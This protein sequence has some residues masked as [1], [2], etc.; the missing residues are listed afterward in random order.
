VTAAHAVNKLEKAKRAVLSRLAPR[1]VQRASKLVAMIAGDDAARR[2]ELA[3][4][5][6]TVMATVGNFV[7]GRR[8]RRILEEMD[9]DPRLSFQAVLARLEQFEGPQRELAEAE[10][11]RMVTHLGDAIAPEA[12]RPML[13]AVA[14]WCEDS[15]Q[16]ED[17]VNACRAL[18]DLD[19]SELDQLA[20]LVAQSLARGDSELRLTQTGR[21]ERLLRRLEDCD[22]AR[23]EGAEIVLKRRR[24]ELLRDILLGSG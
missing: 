13:R 18:R 1:A 9:R 3:G 20:E 19:G 14:V 8:A 4:A 17:C 15:L 24:A 12:V 23:L 21:A 16:R 6:T 2:A 22:L 10:V 7:S 5:F 11:R